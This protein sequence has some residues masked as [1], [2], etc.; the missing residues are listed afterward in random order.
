[1]ATE[2]AEKKYLPLFRKD[3][4]IYRGPDDSDGAP[5]YNLLDPIRGQYYK[6]SWKESLIFRSLKAD[7]TAEDLAQEINKI[8]TLQIQPDDLPPFFMQLAALDLLR[9]SRGSE[10][11]QKAAERQDQG[12]WVWL[13]YHYLYIRI[14]LI[15]PDKFLAKALPYVK[16]LGSSRAFFVY[17]LITILGLYFVSRQWDAFI[18]TFTYFFNLQGIIIYALAIT[19]LKI[20]HE[21]SHAFVAK[22]YGLHVPSMG[23]ALIVLWPVLYTDVTDGW[24]LSNRN[25]RLAISFAGIAA[26]LVAAGIATYGWA[27]SSPGMFQS[28]LFVIASTSWISTLAINLNP[29][30]RFDGYYI[31]CDLWGIDNLQTCAFNVTRWKFLET[32]FGVKSPC[33]IENPPR[34]R[35][36]GLI[37]YAI[38]TIVYR[39]FLYMAVALFVYYEFTKALGILLFFAEIAIFMVWPLTYEIK[40]VY[41]VRKSINMNSKTWLA[42]GIVSLALAWFILPLPTRES[43]PAAIQSIQEQAVYVPENSIIQQIA[44]SKGDSVEQGQ[45]LLVLKSNDV[46]R[47]LGQSL[48][49]QQL[50]EQEILLVSLDSSLQNY[51]SA[52]EA[53]LSKARNRLEQMSKKRDLLTIKAEFPGVVYAWNDKLHVGNSVGEGTEIGR[54]AASKG[55]YAVAYVPEISIKDF[56]VGQRATVRSESRLVNYQ[57]IVDLI[58]TNR[59]IVLTHPAL[60][61]YNRGPLPVMGESNEGAPLYLVESYYKVFVKIEADDKN[62][63]FYGEPVEVEIRG[64]W[65]SK[66]FSFFNYLYTIYLR[67]S[68]L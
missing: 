58:S 45:T 54:I 33:P 63:F 7:M 37:C 38:F 28:V 12:F 18:H 27:L 34:G 67:E 32:F 52:K 1:M 64:P 49:D 31:L 9:I 2:S 17:T 11:Y 6:I 3:L 10:Y 16:F 53:E 47:L 25:Q 23:I 48:L 20:I 55:L 39:I 36:T 19:T 13:L 50:I 59:D 26:E 42:A 22:R 41:M 24:K 5:T 60:A 8:S 51:R 30:V 15:N 46:L 29:A 56:S 35:I 61:S 21:F 14:P 66:L 57:G 40:Q 65:R 44:V 43:F 68:S 62:E 4:Q